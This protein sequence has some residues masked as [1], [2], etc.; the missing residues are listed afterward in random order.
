M[1]S[2]KSLETGEEYRD[3]YEN[4][5][6]CL[7]PQNQ[8][9]SLLV[10]KIAVDFW[11]LRRVIRFETG[12]ISKY[13]EDIFK[14]FYDYSKK[15]NVKIDQE[16]EELKEEINWNSRYLKY[17]EKHLVSF[18]KPVW[19]KDDMESHIVE[20]FYMILGNIPSNELSKQ[21]REAICYENMDFHET[22]STTFK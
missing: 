12:S 20:D 19:K 17:L 14:N 1:V 22:K 13:L 10:E 8:L 3:I 18:D 11:R 6:I 7:C 21:E 16:I 5:K 15:D 9:E 2:D 4:L